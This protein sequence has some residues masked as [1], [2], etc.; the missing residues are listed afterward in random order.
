MKMYEPELPVGI[1]KSSML[2]PEI[3]KQA[4]TWCDNVYKGLD[5]YAK[6]LD[7]FV[8]DQVFM[9]IILHQIETDK[10][11]NQYKVALYCAKHKE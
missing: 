6:F 9:N 5:R 1:K 11:A 10:R 3:R 2:T 4:N 7:K 8:K